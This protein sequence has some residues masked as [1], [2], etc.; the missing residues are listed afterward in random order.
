MEARLNI[1]HAVLV[2]KIHYL[3]FCMRKAQNG[4][5]SAHQHGGLPY[6]FGN[7]GPNTRVFPRFSEVGFGLFGR[8]CVSSIIDRA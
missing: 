3:T 7:R 5:Y 8:V 6:S 1:P 4:G 2:G